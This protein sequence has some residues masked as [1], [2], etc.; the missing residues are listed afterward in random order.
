MLD[1]DEF[2]YSKYLVANHNSGY[3]VM[4]GREP[5]Y[6]RH[7]RA[8]E[9]DLMLESMNQ[10]NWHDFL[11]NALEGAMTNRKRSGNKYVDNIFEN[12]RICFHDYRVMLEDIALAYYELL[13]T[14]S[15]DNII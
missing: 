3:L 15:Q 6:C 9:D 14:S 2:L 10:N 7:S 4:R 8:M 5:I 1:S 11:D 13:L 12:L